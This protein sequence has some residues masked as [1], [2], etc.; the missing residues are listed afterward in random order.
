MYQEIEGIKV[1]GDPIE[2]AVKQIVDASGEAEYSALMADAH[3]GYEVPIGAVMAY[4]GKVSPAG[5][6]FDIGCGNMAVRLDVP[7]EEIQSDMEAIMDEV[8]KTF[9]FGT[10]KIN[11]EWDTV[12]ADDIWDSPVWNLPP[13]KTISKAKVM[14]QLGSVG[15][16]NHY[17]DLFHD[18]EDRVWVGV[19]FGS[20]GFGHKIA[21]YFI[22]ALGKG[23]N[24]LVDTDTDMGADYVECMNLA[25]LYAKR[26]R[27]WV[28]G[29]VAKI[30]QAEIKESV[31]NHHNF[32]WRE[33]HLGKSLWVVRK[34]STPAWPGQKC[35]VGS[36]MTD[37]SYIL[38]GRDTEESAATLYSTIH[39]AGRIMSRTQAAGKAKR[40]G[41][42][43]V[44]RKGG[45]I[46]RQDMIDRVVQHGVELRGAGTDEAPQAY[47]KLD[48][49]LEHHKGTVDVVHTLT[50]VGVAMAGSGYRD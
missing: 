6:G 17:I 8:W 19:H 16:G 39:G 27:E 43:V 18:Q 36:N 23:V 38:R 34:G 47:K 22:G 13:S 49:V 29:R 32:A 21:S 48:E 14:R 42:K 31:H 1:W 40:R 45:K 37:T 30:L 26:G 24:L 12:D 3:H 15:S 25:G 20:R 35:F 9:S 5:V 7:Y 28:C 10:G 33:E 50:P 2:N 4:D 46:S 11:D 44:G 41:G